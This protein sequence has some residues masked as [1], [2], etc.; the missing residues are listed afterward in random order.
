MLAVMKCPHCQQGIYANFQASQAVPI[1]GWHWML[2][3]LVC[4]EC[5]TPIVRVLKTPSTGVVGRTEYP[6][7]PANAST[8]PVPPDV[9]DPYKKDFEEA[10]AVLPISPKASAA[11]SRRNLQAILKDQAKTKKKDLADQISEVIATGH[12][13]THIQEGLD[14]VRNIGNFAAHAIKSTST[15]EI[16]DVEPGEA[17]W[18]LDIL[19]SL[20]DFYFVQPA[21][22]AK[23]RAALDAK[24]KDANKPPLK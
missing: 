21:L 8:R 2:M 17:E 6:A 7:F 24:L 19:Q 22:T 18:D 1:L 4:P 3:H 10:C 12:I 14:A 11:L 13:P 9:M 15:G 23:R 5:N 20:F 16:V